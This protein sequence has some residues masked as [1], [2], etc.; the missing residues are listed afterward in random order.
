MQVLF[1]ISFFNVCLMVTYE[2]SD[3]QN[4][5]DDKNIIKILS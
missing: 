1:V 2:Q 4:K 5:F 3:L